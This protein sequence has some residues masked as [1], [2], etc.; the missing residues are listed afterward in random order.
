MNARYTLLGLFALLAASCSQEENAILDN[1]AQE[2]RVSAGIST[3]TRVALNDYGGD[4]TY[5]HW[6]DGDEIA[7]FTD[8]QSNLVYST[9]IGNTGLTWDSTYVDFTPKGEA[10]K[11]VEGGT[12]YACYPGITAADGLV[13]SMPSTKAFKYDNGVI[14]SFAYAVG[15]IS[16]GNV[17]F[18]FK[19]ISAFLN[20]TLLPT[21]FE[22]SSSEPISSIVVSTSSSQP[23]ST[24][25]W[26][27]FDFS[28]L[29]ANVTSGSNS[30]E[31]YTDNYLLTSPWI[32]YVPVLPQPAD[33]SITI[34]LKGTNGATLYSLTKQAPDTGLLAGNVYKVTWNESR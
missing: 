24:G 1:V 17:S 18:T 30:V 15:T 32:V 10:L 11:N 6:R 23:L 34:T 33:A 21:L 20:L 2:V 29:T 22:T 31:V 4:Y 13:V 5:T 27:T 8:T 19:H 3:N 9:T 12:V 14:P 26:D 16:E 7:L 25:E 28:T